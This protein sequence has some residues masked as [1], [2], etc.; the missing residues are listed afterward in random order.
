MVKAGRQ[1]ISHLP[2]E[3]NALQVALLAWRAMAQE[4]ARAAGS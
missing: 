4:A 1:A 3:R 2:M